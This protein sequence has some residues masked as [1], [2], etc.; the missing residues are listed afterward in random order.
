MHESVAAQDVL[1]QRCEMDTERAKDASRA[2]LLPRDSTDDALAK[3]LAMQEEP[4]PIA[5]TYKGLRRQIPVV[6][7]GR[8][9][10][11]P[12]GTAGGNLQRP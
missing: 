9:R 8:G 12:Y 2:G 11:D 1:C 5:S 7:R 10:R 6:A 3:A 4:V